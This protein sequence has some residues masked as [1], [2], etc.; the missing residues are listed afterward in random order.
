MDPNRLHA[1]IRMTIALAVAWA[2]IDN[3]AGGSS[4]GGRAAVLMAHQHVAAPPMRHTGRRRRTAFSAGSGTRTVAGHRK[5]PTCSMPRG[6]PPCR[7]W[8]SFTATGRPPTPRSSGC[9]VYQIL[10]QEA[11]DPRVSLCDLVVAQRSRV[12]AAPTRCPTEAALRRRRKLLSCPMAGRAAAQDTRLFDR[13]QSRCEDHHRFAANGGGRRSGRTQSGSAFHGN[14]RGGATTRAGHALRRR[15]RQRLAGARPSQRAGAFLGRTDVD[16]RNA[17]DHVLRWYPRIFG[18]RGPSAM[19]FVGPLLG[20]GA[21]QVEVVDVSD[22]V[23]KSHDVRCCL[24][25]A[26]FRCRLARYAFLD[27]VSPAI[28]E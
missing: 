9:E 27:G 13:L 24:A 8:F 7:R 4:S 3:C 5:K 28:R 17:C 26:E 12:H 6:I 1:L 25:S 18:R 15:D 16:T 10:R 21:N 2:L 23:G 11:C 19:G 22:S 20:D 14:Q